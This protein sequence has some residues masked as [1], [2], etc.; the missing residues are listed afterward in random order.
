[1]TLLVGVGT[2]QAHHS[3]AAEFDASKPVHLSGTIVSI[4]LTNPHAEIYLQ[5]G[6]ARWWIE[7]ASPNALA[8]RGI[9]KTTMHAGMHVEIDGY[10]AK[11]GSARAYGIDLHLEDGRVLAL[12]PKIP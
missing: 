7:A 3:F 5:S 10:Q 9:T 1:M 8:R 12:N 4:A 11:D 2:A 6:T